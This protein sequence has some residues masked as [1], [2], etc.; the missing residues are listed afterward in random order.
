MIITDIPTL[1][2]KNEEA[3]V[4][5]AQEIIEE[6]ERELAEAG[7]IGLSANQIGIHKKVAIVRVKNEDEEE[8][9]NLVNPRIVEKW[10]NF[11]CENEGCLSLPGVLVNTNRCNEIFVKDDLHSAG[12][13]ATGLAAVAVQHEI[14]HL[15]NILITDRVAGKKKIGRNDPC[16]CGKM[17]NGKPVKWKKCHGK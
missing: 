10:G 1:R 4:K 15:E 9:L 6:L 13:I 16:P 17:K 7:G 14:D 8:S 2:K 5:E 3:S 11:I 12:F